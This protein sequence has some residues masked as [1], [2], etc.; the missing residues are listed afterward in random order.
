MTE[1]FPSS[2]LRFAT[3][4]VLAQAYGTSTY[5]GNSYNGSIITE[6]TPVREVGAPSTGFFAQPPII[7]LPGLLVLAIILGSISFAISRILRRR[8]NK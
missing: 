5:N 7:V 4:Q 1:E 8:R 6:P 3:S 2:P